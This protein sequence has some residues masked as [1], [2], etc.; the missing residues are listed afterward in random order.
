MGINDF[1]I[2]GAMEISASGLTAQR[3][4]LDLIAGNIANANTPVQPG[5]PPFRRQLAVLQAKQDA[6]GVGQGVEVSQIVEDPQMKQVYDPTNPLA[7]AQ[8]Y[9]TVPDV[10]VTQEMVDMMQSTRAYDAN[11]TAMNASKSIATKT[12]DLLR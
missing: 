8:G 3:T 10:N 5:V 12:L 2:Y 7:N 6:S 1:S 11:V 4:R 9:I